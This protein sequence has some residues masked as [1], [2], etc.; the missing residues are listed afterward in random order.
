MTTGAPSAAKRT[1][2]P[3]LVQAQTVIALPSRLSGKGGSGGRRGSL[4]CYTALCP[5]WSG[6]VKGSE[7]WGMR[8]VQ[9]QL[10]L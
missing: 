6:V 1:E 2:V 10:R 4:S 9:S 3:V 8:A 5:A 7:V